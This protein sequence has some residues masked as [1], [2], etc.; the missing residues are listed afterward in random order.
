MSVA[1]A[2]TWTGPFYEVVNGKRYAVHTATWLSDGSGNVGVGTTGNLAPHVT[3]YVDYLVTAPGAATPTSYTV[4][5]VENK[6]TRT[7]ATAATRSTTAAERTDVLQTVVSNKNFVS[8]LYIT[9][10]GAG[11]NKTGTV[12]VYVQQ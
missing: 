12:D 6:R 7:L 2:V 10:S 9:I 8:R 5:L 4:A 3:G 1:A 11:D